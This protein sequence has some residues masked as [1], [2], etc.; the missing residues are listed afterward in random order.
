MKFILKNFIWLFFIGLVIGNVYI[1]ISGIQLGN[2]VNRYEGEINRLHQENTDL[3][4]KVFEVESLRHTASM[5]AQ[6]DFTE[7]STPLILD[8]SKY[9]LNR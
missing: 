2:E 7:Q 1:F 5:A 6:L 4:K 3:E 8:N 9:A